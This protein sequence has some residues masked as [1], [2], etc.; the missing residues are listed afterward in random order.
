MNIYLPEN[1]TKHLIMVG[2]HQGGYFIRYHINSNVS[3]YDMWSLQVVY[4]TN[5]Y[6]EGGNLCVL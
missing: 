5:P 2:Q 1:S 4:R 3:S 6:P